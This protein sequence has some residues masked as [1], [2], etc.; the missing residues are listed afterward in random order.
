MEYLYRYECRHYSSKDAYTE[1]VL[2]QRAQLYC[3]K[4]KVTSLTPKGCWI[5]V[6]GFNNRWVSNTS[7]KRFAHSTKIEAIEAYKIR[8]SYYV[9]YCESRLNKA[10]QELK[11]GKNWSDL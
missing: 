11:A 1:Q 3:E 2:P 7:R 4:F 9:A 10:K 6:F 8:K 5:S